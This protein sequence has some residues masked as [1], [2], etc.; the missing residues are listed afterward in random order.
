MAQVLPEVRE[1]LE[2]LRGREM[3]FHRE[4]SSFSEAQE[5]RFKHD[6]LQQVAYE[7][8][9]KKLRRVYHA[10]V[11]EW[12]IEKSSARSSELLGLIATHLQ[13]AGDGERAV[14][15]YY[16]AGAQALASFANQDAEKQFAAALY[17]VEDGRART[18]ILAGLGK[19]QEAQSQFEEAIQTW[20]QA[21]GLFVEQ[22]DQDRTA[23]L[24]GL[25]GRAACDSGDVK[26][27]LS[28]C[29][30][31]LAG[32]KGAAPGP[33]MASLLTD[34]ARACYLNGVK[35]E[36]E[37]YAGEALVMAVQ[38]QLPAMQADA[39][40]NMALVDF[41]SAASLQQLQEAIRIAE[42]G[43]HNRQVARA[44]NNLALV[45]LN[46]GEFEAAM[47][48]YRRTLASYRLVGNTNGQLYTA[49]NI[50]MTLLILGRPDEVEAGLAEAE[51]LL[52]ILSGAASGISRLR[53]EVAELHLRRGEF[54]DLEP[55][56]ET[57]GGELRRNNDQQGLLAVLRTH[58]TYL[59]L[60][61][62]GQEAEEVCQEFIKIAHIEN[63][64]PDA[65]CCAFILAGKKGDPA[66][67][68]WHLQET[69]K[70]IEG[71]E[72]SFLQRHLYF[73]RAEAHLLAAEQ[74]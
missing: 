58:L 68:L 24:V 28:I 37:H 36:I 20:K 30:Q 59:L 70:Y 49:G 12:L 74:K 46:R 19:A 52:R 13:K 6:L 45:Y 56:I 65:H 16:R 57:L 11:A 50:F 5:Y 8:V 67:G 2:A 51:G 48:H 54:N 29:R 18:N 47:E 33:G 10:L 72:P 22:G 7:S 3:V 64:V 62:S 41:H 42:A 63:F 34:T 60:M 43:H 38:L 73:A 17:L 66:Q 32:L 55:L 4:Y 44:H 27:G 69:R 21:I 53:C 61:D 31:G 40:I 14:D 25:S 26:R 1:T 39:L 23:E 71:G 35:D 9:L 15:Y